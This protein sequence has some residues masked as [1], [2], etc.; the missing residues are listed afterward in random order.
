MSRKYHNLSDLC[1]KMTQQCVSKRCQ[2]IEEILNDIHLFVLSSQEFNPNEE[3]ERV[4]SQNNNNSY[5]YKLTKHILN[6]TNSSD[7][8]SLT[9]ADFETEDSD[10]YSSYYSDRDNSDTDS[11]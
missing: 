8:D 5:V 2:T 9:S 11:K 4:L 1:D 3:L 7:D 6:E 10:D